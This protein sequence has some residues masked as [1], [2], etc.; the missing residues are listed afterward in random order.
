MENENRRINRRIKFRD[1]IQYEKV[2]KDGSFSIAV[3]TKAKDITKEGISFYLEE[4]LE[5]NSV[6]RIKMFRESSGGISYLGRVRWVQMG[7]DEMKYLIGVKIEDISEDSR[8]KLNKFL[9]RADLFKVIDELNLEKVV[10]LQLVSGY[11]PIL[12]RI[13]SMEISKVEPFT[14]ES[15]R[16]ALLD[17]LDAKQYKQFLINKEMNFVFDYNEKIRF[18]VNLHMQ[19][20]KVEGTFRLIPTESGIPSALGLPVIVDKLM[21]NKKGLILIA[22]RTGAGKTTTLSSMVELINNKKENIIITIEDPVEYLH[23]NKKS[24]IKQ[25]EVGRDTLSFA[26][27]AKNALRQN[28]DVLVIGEIL[29]METME[30]AISAAESGVLVLSSIHGATSIQ[31]LD[32]VTSFFPADMQKHILSRLA[33]MLK[34]VITQELLPR[35]DGE[36]LLIAAEVLVM[37]SAMKRLVKEGEWYQIPSIIETGKNMGMQSMEASIMK[38]YHDDLIDGEYIREYMK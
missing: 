32:R 10:D 36:G 11:P 38:Y 29:D 5:L 7:D 21:E 16:S 18:R 1:E 25:R 31:A 23:I 34:G 2:F 6:I 3:C 17:C 28:P 4:P 19:M 37:S 12:K 22:G 8:K 30:V 35:L 9:N 13:G 27:A 14:E 26:K 24:I 20:G 33:L 15:L